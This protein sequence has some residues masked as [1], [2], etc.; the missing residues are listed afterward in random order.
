MKK[1]VSFIGVLAVMLFVAGCAQSTPEEKYLSHWEK[2]VSL[3]K[4]NKTDTAKAQAAVKGY[5]DA[6]LA[7]MKTLSTQ[8]GQASSKDIAKNSVYIMRV[9]KLVDAITELAKSNK[10]LLDDP[11]LAQ[12]YAPLADL[13]K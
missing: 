7:D 11:Q 10:A 2:I 1:A 9:L 5:L 8:F 6:N 3:I 12:A 4:D 13:T